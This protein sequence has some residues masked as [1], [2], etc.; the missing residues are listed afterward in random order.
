MYKVSGID[1]ISHGDYD[2]LD[3]GSALVFQN[4]RNAIGDLTVP[5][6]SLWFTFDSKKYP[7]QPDLSNTS[8]RF[9]S[10]GMVY[11][12]WALFLLSIFFN[13]IILLNFLIAIIS[14]SYDDVMGKEK[15][16]RYLSRC[17]LNAEVAVLSDAFSH[18]FSGNDDQK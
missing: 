1:P 12:G 5:S 13:L 9:I 4:F 2:N 10:Y 8:Q 7:N 3:M 6:N 15:M 14:Q 16:N 18:V 17:D 11:W